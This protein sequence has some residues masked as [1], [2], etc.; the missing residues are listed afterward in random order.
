MTK[1]VGA[2]SSAAVSEAEAGLVEQWRSVQDAYLRTSN[3]IERELESK[4]NIGCS[5]FE[6]LDLLAEY[7][8]EPCRMKDLT[9]VSPLTQSALSR[10]VDR[11]EKAGLVDRA[12]C[13]D[14]RRS[15]NVMLTD[16]GCE[17][18]TAAAKTQRAVLKDCL[19]Q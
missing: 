4:F 18:Y 16:K 11:L 1:T 2:H 17:V 12:A 19:G 8:E 10:I 5:E 6:I 3:A 15:M 13:T 7:T 9:L 14:D